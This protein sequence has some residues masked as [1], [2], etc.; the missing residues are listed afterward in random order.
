MHS[1]EELFQKLQKKYNVRGPRYTSYPPANHFGPLDQ[2]QL[3]AYWQQRQNLK[4]DN[5]ISLYLHIPFCETRCAFCG[6]HTYVKP[7]PLLVDEYVQGL[8]RE[9]EKVRIQVGV[10]RAVVQIALGGGTPH[11]LSVAQLHNL[12]SEFRKNWKLAA[13]VEFSAELDPRTITVE[14]LDCLKEYGCNRFSLGVQDFE[15]LVLNS[16]RKNQNIAHIDK[17][18]G[19]I[20]NRERNFIN[21]DLI[22]GLPGQT[23]ESAKRTSQ[24]VVQ[25][26]PNR[27]ALF[28]YAHIPWVQPHQKALEKKEFP[29]PESK[30]DI[31]LY[32][33]NYFINS[34]YQTIGMDHFALPD[35]LLVK[36]QVANKLWRNFMG[37]TPLREIDLVGMG[38]S[39]ISCVG[40]A[41]S[42][43]E[44]D[45]NKYLHCLKNQQSPV[46]RGFIL[47]EEDEIRRELIMTLFCNFYV[48]WKEFDSRWKIDHDFFFEHELKELEPMI[49]DGLLTLEPN[50]I[51]VTNIGKFFIRNICMVFD[52]YLEHESQRVYSRTI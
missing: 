18:V 28:N 13:D 34:G 25:F 14:K 48:N 39:A 33:R 37:Y 20:R 11:Y 50:F 42:Q 19:W 23:L 9:M 38:A 10:Q 31:F 27:I 32:M 40:K 5:G 30:S 47:S 24:K 51:N 22:Y 15:P 26:L 7:S 35:D 12:L 29:S 41:Y 1:S 43:N 17:V 52:S 16:L 3:L 44:K 8:I 49:S 4:N 6:C 46:V 45:L 21:F 36:A 2:N